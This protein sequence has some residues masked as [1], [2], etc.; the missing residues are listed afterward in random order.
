[1]KSAA[2]IDLNLL[3]TMLDDGIID[4]IAYNKLVS[5]AVRT[6]GS[7]GDFV[8]GTINTSVNPV[9]TRLELI[10]IAVKKVYPDVVNTTLEI[11]EFT[12][13]NILGSISKLVDWKERN[14]KA[15]DAEG[16]VLTNM[17]AALNKSDET[18]LS[19]VDAIPTNVE[20]EEKIEEN[21]DIKLEE[22]E[23]KREEEESTIIKPKKK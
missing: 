21:T 11:P 9:K 4:Q 22:E 19:L 16:N 12:P 7:I 20:T 18:E 1:M 10:Y 8:D 15:K 5:S 3:I 6:G 13:E 17:I 23:E 2:S 14:V